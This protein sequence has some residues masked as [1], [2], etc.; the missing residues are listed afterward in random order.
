MNKLV[1]LD[2]NSLIN[3]AFYAL[4]ALTDTKG[5]ITNAVYGFSSM[6]VRIIKELNPTHLVAT[7]DLKAPTFRHKMYSEYKGTRK[8][9]PL[10]LVSQL[11]LL[12]DLLRAMNIAIVEIEGY[13]ADDIIGTLARKTPFDTVVVSGDKD[14]LQ[15]VGDTTRVWLTKKGISNVE[16]YDLISLKAQNM[17][18]NKVIELKSLMGDASD[19]IPGVSGVGE[20][21]AMTLLDKYET[22]D[23]IYAHIDEINGKL[24]ENLIVNK[25]MA[26]LSRKLATIDEDIPIDC[27]LTKLVFKYPFKPAVREML[28]DYELKTLIPRFQYDEKIEQKLT[29]A[30][31]IQIETIA[32]I[33]SLSNSIKVAGIMAINIDSDFHIAYNTDTEYV[34]SP[35]NDLLGTINYDDVIR[36]LKSVLYNAEI[37]KVVFDYKALK[38]RL[39]GEISGLSDDIMLKAYVA[40]AG[41]SYNNVIDLLSSNGMNGE[42][43]AVEMLEINNELEI[44][45]EDTNTTDLYNNIEMPL[46]HVLYEME[47]TGFKVNK[48]VL[49]ELADKFTSELNELTKKIY[50]YSGKH[51]N[52]N[53]GRQLGD[54][55]FNDLN[56]PS[57]KKNKTGFSLSGD[58]LIKMHNMHPIIDL[59]IKYRH[60]TK[61]LATY[62]DGTRSQISSDGNVHTI[63]KQ[64]STSTGRLSSTEPNMQNIPIRDEI[65]REIRRMFIASPGNVLIC[66]DYSQIELRLLAHFSGDEKLVKSYINGE[67]I[68]ARTAAEILDVNINEVTSDMR[69]KAKAV[70]FGIIFGIS[71]Y[72][73]SENVDISVKAAKEYIDKYFKTYPTV[74]EYMDRNIAIAK[75]TGRIKT[76]TGRLRN[77]PEL[78]SDNFNVRSFGERAA[79]N[80]PLQGSAADLIKIAMINVYKALNKEQLKSK[81]ILQIHDEL[82][83]D[84]LASE[85]EAVRRILT[86]E[87]EGAVALRVPLVV[88]ISTGFSLYEAL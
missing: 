78:L 87:M 58:I 33:T 41:T 14:T 27:D 82:I 54:I 45:L 11:P 60:L 18:P 84:T 43:L 12:K 88:D 64:A 51:F 55:L 59:I 30:K 86:D 32:Q 79:M 20:K 75:E 25:D 26:Y 69:R 15:L 47:K 61:L 23:N 19:N 22:L 16:E 4:P 44:K 85:E 49:E 46:I 40:N 56:L 52:I 29:E 65:G 72:G 42:M 50:E 70:N 66:A 73:L 74:K 6:L 13:E 17:T 9:M 83:V 62:I 80:M 1:L 28:I 10:E 5:R 34:I 81:L 7:F 71:S 68:H 24:K 76:I 77:I 37:K 21:T 57:I 48:A 36:S 38:Q 35:S 39:N 3:R 8:P 31:K 67:D 2:S 53:S 63:F